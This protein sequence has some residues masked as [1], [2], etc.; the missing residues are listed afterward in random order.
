MFVRIFKTYF[1]LV[2]NELS[3]PCLLSAVLI[4][5]YYIVKSKQCFK[6]KYYKKCKC[7]HKS[8]AFESYLPELKIQF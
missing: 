8:V 5:E 4:I 6:T 7:R 1:A 2:W 3:S